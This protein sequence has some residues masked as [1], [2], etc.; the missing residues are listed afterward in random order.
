MRASGTA[1]QWRIQ[2]FPHIAKEAKDWALA[3]PRLGAAIGGAGEGIDAEGDSGRA[4]WNVFDAEGFS[5][6][7]VAGVYQAVISD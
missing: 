2:S 5:E 4:A 6:C 1:S 7:G 3:D